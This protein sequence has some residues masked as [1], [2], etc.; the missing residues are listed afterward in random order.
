MDNNAIQ[1]PGVQVSGSDHNVTGPTIAPAPVAGPA[2]SPSPAMGLSCVPHSAPD[3]ALHRLQPQSF[4]PCPPTPVWAPPQSTAH[5]SS[6]RGLESCNTKTGLRCGPAS[7][8]RVYL[9]RLGTET[10]AGAA[11]CRMRPFPAGSTARAQPGVS[12][13]ATAMAPLK[14]VRWRPWRC[15][16]EAGRG[17]H[18]AGAL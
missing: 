8:G 5:P 4:R 18:S 2:V 15:P 14:K 13:S 6:T 10:R 17:E 11:P 1:H 3:V 7:L 9:A 16:R 12:P